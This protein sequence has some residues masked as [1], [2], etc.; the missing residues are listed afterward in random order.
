MKPNMPPDSSPVP[1]TRQRVYA[2]VSVAIAV[3]SVLVLIEGMVRLLSHYSTPETV[4]RNSLEYMGS[5]FARHRLEPNQTV[6]V[7]E[8]RRDASSAEGTARVFRIGR[9]GYRGKEFALPKPPGLRRIVIFGGSAV[10]DIHATEGRDWPHLVEE[11]I[12][13]KGHAEV[14]VINAGIPGHATFD[15]LGRL[16]SQVWTY[17][18]DY[19][20]IYEAWN[21][22]KYIDDVGF[23]T[24]LIDQFTPYNPQTDPFRNFLGPVDRF[25]GHSQLYVRLR[26]R[27]FRWKL[28]PGEEG[29]RPAEEPIR[30]GSS[31]GLRQYRLNLEL[32]V[33]AARDIGATP[34]LLT[35]ATLVSATNT[36]EDKKHIRYDYQG[37]NHEQL[38]KAFKDCNDVVRLVAREK[39]APLVDLDRM[40]TGRRELFE[41]HV[42][43]TAQGSAALGN[44]VGDFF[45]D[46]LSRKPG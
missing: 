4:R 31:L 34:V 3:V 5:I 12:R 27:Y 24:P 17:E 23:E 46:A 29:K 7:E 26:K 10:F 32:F 21:D 30:P 9:R 36:E 1:P 6:R 16:Y 18:P 13:S 35:E 40:L 37:M 25:L 42:H 45:A 41:D 44:A 38:I 20:A 14:E 15:A 43:T 8:P 39:E 19:V 11:R 33:D 2:L 22:M 28:N